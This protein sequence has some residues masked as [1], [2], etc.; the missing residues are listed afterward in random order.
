[1][2]WFGFFGEP[3]WSGCSTDKHLILS[4]S[5]INGLRHWR[6]ENFVNFLR[7]HGMSWPILPTG[8]LDQTEQT[9]REMAARYPFIELSAIRCR[10]CG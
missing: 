2:R 5:L 3:D 6:N 10:N 9:F 4:V 7:R 8:A 1:M